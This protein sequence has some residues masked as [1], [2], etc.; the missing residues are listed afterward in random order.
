MSVNS[1]DLVIIMSFDIEK[2]I[3]EVKKKFEEFYFSSK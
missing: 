2:W 1:N 3:I